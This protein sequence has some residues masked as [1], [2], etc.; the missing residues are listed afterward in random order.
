[1]LNIIHLE[2]GFKIDIILR[3]PRAFSV[4]EF[5][6]RCKIN[7]LGKDRWFATPEDTILTKLEWCKLGQSERQYEDALNIAIVQ[8]ETLDFAY[9]ARWSSELGLEDLLNRLLVDAGLKT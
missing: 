8:G 4:E 3:K 7:F 6:R 9:L 5:N 1:M 2:T